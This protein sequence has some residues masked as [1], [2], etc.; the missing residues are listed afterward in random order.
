MPNPFVII[1]LLCLG[2]MSTRSLYAGQAPDAQVKADTLPSFIPGMDSI[3]F[4]EDV[5]V[6]GTRTA[7]RSAESPVMVTVMDSRKMAGLQVCVL[8]D[9]LRF[10][11]GLRVETNCQTC[12]YTQLRMNGLA[13]AYTQILVNGRPLFGPMMSLY[14]MEQLPVNMIDRIEVVRGGGSSLYGPSAIG[15]TVNVI[16]RTPV[17]NE[18]E[19]GMQF[20]H[21]G[22]RTGEAILS[23][24]GSLVS[25][26]KQTGISLFLNRR[27][28]G[29]FDA[30]GDGY[31]ELPELRNLSSGLSFFHKPTKDQKL[32]LS[33]GYL[34]EYRYG[35]EITDRAVQ[36]AGQ[37]EER[38]HRTWM[39]SM[40]Y[41][42]NFN[43]ARSSFIAYGGWQ[44]IRRSHYTG[45]LPDESAALAQH[46]LVPPF[47]EADAATLNTG[48]QL[49]HRFDRFLKGEN[50]FTLGSEFVY[51]KV[52]DN[53]PAYRYQVDQQTRD[54]GVFLQS[55]WQLS[56]KL[57]MLSGIRA[58]LHSMLP[59]R[60]M[61]SPRL[62]LLYRPWSSTQIRL[63]YGKGFRAPQAFDTDLHLAFAGGGVSRIRLDNDLLAER[64]NSWSL[65]WNADHATENRIF[66]YTVE[67]FSTRLLGAFN[68]VHMGADAYGEIFE[69]RNGSGARVQGVTIE[70]RGNF[71]K[72]L[73]I[74][75]GFT[76][77][78]SIY[79]D[80]VDYLNGVPPER[81][82]LRT[83]DLYGFSSL[84]Y[85]PTAKWNIN[86]SHVH[87]G[88]MR[89]VHF[90]SEG[91]QQTDR[92]VETKPFDEVNLR[93]SRFIRVDDL[94]SVIECSAGVR[95]LLNA[96]QDD[97]DRGKYRDSNYIY[98]PALPRSL[99][100][101]VK[102]R[103][104]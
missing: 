31:S 5:V 17:R 82:F 36:L 81:D 64:S 44:F 80:A 14:G 16:S 101:A 39:G 67:A 28:R 95:N 33:I 73:Q 38:R 86:L 1:L 88:R 4:M 85:M 59:G 58:D 102:W 26:D 50:T 77:Q 62:S 53:I 20:Q 65:S 83:P 24:N 84:T 48:F 79:D 61:M 91:N 18:A 71:R 7:R 27:D 72:K 6:T 8:S 76:L 12:N 13:G 11:P 37:A 22:G 87:T 35:G 104:N 32:E 51:D 3:R 56:T 57:T 93:V 66:G 29:V 49:N 23:G 40:D 15:G 97:F 46:I 41:Q 74:E 63:G 43:E 45:V 89:L 68:L 98:G 90:G 34:G 47:G 78:Q 30:N 10:Q 9:A 96:W 52:T 42:V 69:K 19:V 60:I 21:I 25:T 92:M 54:F 100:I 55:D 99:F 103:F 70:L 2:V 94:S 75:G